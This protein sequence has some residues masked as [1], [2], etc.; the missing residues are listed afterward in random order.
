MPVHDGIWHNKAVHEYEVR[1]TPGKILPRDYGHDLHDELIACGVFAK[2]AI[3]DEMF[4]GCSILPDKTDLI[5][6]K[7]GLE[8]GE[9]SVDD[10]YEFCHK[11]GLEPDMESENSVAKFLEFTF[12][13]CVVWMNIPEGRES[14][15][16]IMVALMAERG[17]IVIDVDTW[18][19]VPA[20]GP[21]P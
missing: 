11:H 8:R 16:P 19:Q 2:Y 13:C 7:I 6:L 5:N 17:L 4:W 15:L 20:Y 21:K 18:E 12:G 10:F 14:L 1:S 9:F 3:T